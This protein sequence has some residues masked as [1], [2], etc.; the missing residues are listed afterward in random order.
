MLDKA[1]IE[2]KLVFIDCYT[3]WCAP[4]KWMDK[5]VFVKEEVYTFFNENFI[6]YKIDME[7]GEGPAL[8]KR[9]NVNSYPTYLFVDSKGNLVHLAKSRMEVEEFI[10]EAKNALN[11]EKAFGKLTEK[12]QSGTMNLNQLASYAIQ[13]NK[14]G[15][16]DGGKIVDEILKKAD[17][18]WMKSEIGWDLIE[19]FTKDK[20]SELFKVLNANRDFYERS[21]GKE[22]IYSIYRGIL[23]RELY[24]YSRNGEKEMFFQSLDSLK[25]LNAPIRDIAIMHSNFYLQ[26]LDVESYIETS[27]MYVDQYLQQDEETIAFIAKSVLNYHTEDKALMQQ[28]A[29]IIKKAYAMAP[30]NYGIVSTYAQILGHIGEKTEAIKAAELAVAMADTISSKVKDCALKNLEEIKALK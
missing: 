4:C 10:Q 7:K 14:L 16:R 29:K 1:A 28:A 12:Y 17:S 5:N 26:N 19:S 13:L 21:Y 15:S 6:N 11:P 24:Q 8:G 9:Y 23:Q 20:E 3:S 2:D 30:D 25:A 27:D 22:K 18:Q